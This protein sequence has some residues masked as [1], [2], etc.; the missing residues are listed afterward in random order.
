[1]VSELVSTDLYL[2][3]DFPFVAH[4]PDF[5]IRYGSVEV[6]LQI[7]AEATREENAAAWLRA[8]LLQGRSAATPA[9]EAHAQLGAVSPR[10]RPPAP[11]LSTAKKRGKSRGHLHG[12]FNACEPRTQVSCR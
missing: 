6:P 11:R 2:F 10:A 1:M 4:D 3:A 5:C 12:A 8:C 7:A 9:A